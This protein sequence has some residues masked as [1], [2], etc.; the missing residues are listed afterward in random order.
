MAESEVGVNDQEQI[1]KLAYYLWEWAGKP[2]G[3]D[4]EFWAEAESRW[5]AIRPFFV[6]EQVEQ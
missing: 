4:T 3:M 6:E 5:K 1:R 2:E